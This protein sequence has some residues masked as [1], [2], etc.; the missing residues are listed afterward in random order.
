M[1]VT[2]PLFAWKWNHRV[3]NMCYCC[4]W[5]AKIW[6]KCGKNYYGCSYLLN[7][8]EL[9]VFVKTFLF[10]KYVISNFTQSNFSLCTHITLLSKKLLKKIEQRVSLFGMKWNTIR[11]ENIQNQRSQKKMWK[12]WRVKWITFKDSVDSLQIKKK[13]VDIACKYPHPSFQ[14]GFMIPV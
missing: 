12:V 13:T 11:I 9:S 3:K 14:L 4:C 1:N 8:V 2:I 5:G 6:N 7:T 10:F